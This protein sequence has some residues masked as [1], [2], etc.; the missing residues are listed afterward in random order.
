MSPLFHLQRGPDPDLT[1]EA[2]SRLLRI[3]LT[4]YGFIVVVALVWV[5]ACSRLPIH[6]GV[7]TLVFAGP[8]PAPLGWAEDAVDV[9]P[10]AVWHD[11]IEFERVVEVR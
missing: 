1:P 9:P 2:S 5:W 10:G 6:P 11:V 4:A 3:E 7:R 8:L